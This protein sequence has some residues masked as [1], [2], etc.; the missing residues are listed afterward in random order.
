MNRDGGSQESLDADSGGTPSE[1]LTYTP[2]N[3][4]SYGADQNAY[5]TDAPAYDTYAQSNAGYGD[6]DYSQSQP[7]EAT[8]AYGAYPEY[9]QGQEVG[10]AYGGG[11]PSLYGQAYVQDP[12]SVGGAGIDYS[13]NPV[14]PPWPGSPDDQQ[15]LTQSIETSIGYPVGSRGASDGTGW[16]SGSSGYGEYSGYSEY[17]T[18]NRDD[19]RGANAS[20]TDSDNPEVIRAEIEQTRSE[21]S[22]TINAIQEK[23]SP[24]NL[25]EQAKESVRDATI[26]RVEQMVSDAK[27][28]ARESG[29]NL[30]QMVRDNPLPAAIVGLGL[31]WLFMKNRDKSQD[32]EPRYETSR[33]RSGTY[34][35]GNY[36][37]NYNRDYEYRS[38]GRS[39]SG[40]SEGFVEGTIDKVRQNPLPAALAGAG[41]LMLMNKGG[42]NKTEMN[43]PYYARYGGYEDEKGGIAST[44]QQAGEKIGD[45]AGDVADKVGD[46][47]GRAGDAIG[48]AAGQVKET[49]GDVAGGVAHTA[50]NVAGGTGD[51]LGK[52]LRTI[53]QNPIPAALAGASIGWLW[54]QSNSEGRQRMHQVGHKVGDVA[55]SA[56]EAV[57]DAAGNV[58]EGVKHGAEAAQTNFQRLLL[59][60]PLAA[61]ALAVGVGAA[62]G[63]AVPETEQEHQILGQT[64]D[65]LVDTAQMVANTALDKVEEVSQNVLQR[66]E[67]TAT[68]A[69]YRVE[70]QVTEM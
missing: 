5:G 10:Q 32:W 6:L 18:Q 49:V 65:K 1:Y 12:E 41:L 21:L 44:V 64:K 31:G 56:G 17:A 28:T 50:G 26:G 61:G 11:D 51:V 16:T 37:G 2:Q 46:V 27:D 63:L 43:R 42:D 38:G 13:S 67:D 30:M 39:Y 69:T 15:P 40:Q 47:A 4:N 14:S 45:T 23:L 24:Q 70:Q 35:G 62:L 59:G 66:V 57:G 60:N 53:G 19:Q 55:G 29:D 36:G 8:A 54:M 34:G 58:A 48:S 3:Q 33:Y 68:D 7:Q 52:V 20:G 25:V 9:A 22:G